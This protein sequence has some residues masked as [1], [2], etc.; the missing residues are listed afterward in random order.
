MRI[1]LDTNIL[2]SGIFFGGPPGRILQAWREGAVQLV[3]SPEILEEYQE[4]LDELGA[5]RPGIDVRPLLDSL[6]V[7][8]ELVVG[9]GLVGRVCDDPDDDKFLACAATAGVTC[10][11]SGDRHLL[12]VP[13]YRGI[14]V[15]KPRTFVDAYLR[16]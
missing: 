15:L 13:G 4:V 12:K 14:E 6:V 10:V 2:V 7:H 8:A 5:S 9:A 11:V 3:L 16:E 1:V